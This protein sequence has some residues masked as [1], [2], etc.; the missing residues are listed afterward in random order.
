MM[1]T[2]RTPDRAPD[3]GSPGLIFLMLFSTHVVERKAAVPDSQLDKEVFCLQVT[4]AAA[5]RCSGQSILGHCMPLDIRLRGRTVPRF[6]WER[7]TGYA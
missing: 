5:S 6:E 1:M 4:A 3:H 2:L 7:C